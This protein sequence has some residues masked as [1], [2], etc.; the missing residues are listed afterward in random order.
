MFVT[1]MA[2]AAALAVPGQETIV[3]KG[4]C[5]GVLLRDKRGTGGFGYDPIFYIP[6]MQR[7]LAELP[8]ETKNHLSHRYHAL[9][10]LWDKVKG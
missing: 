1:L 4:V 5:G 9:R 6:Y 10:K 2:L 7:T 3:T 8:E